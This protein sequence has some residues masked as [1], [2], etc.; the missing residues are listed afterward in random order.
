V[1]GVIVGGAVGIV[2]VG[3]SVARGIQTGLLRAYALLLI[4][5]VAA[6]ALYFL[7]QS[8]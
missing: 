8:S 4:L 3:T 1:Q 7:I 5:G 6:L 2:R